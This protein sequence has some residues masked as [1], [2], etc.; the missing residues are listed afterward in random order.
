MIFHKR[1]SLQIE[2]NNISSIKAQ[3]LDEE[4]VALVHYCVSILYGFFVIFSY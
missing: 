2:D 3:L 1:L 4:G